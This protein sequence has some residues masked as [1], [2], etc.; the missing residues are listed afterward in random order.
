MAVIR[1]F[2]AVRPR[3]EDVAAVAAVP[4][5]V[6]S[7][8][9]AA[10]L[11]A[12]NPLSFLHVSRSEIDLEPGI[13]P[14]SDAVY[15]KAQENYVKLQQTGVLIREQ[16]DS[17]Y[18]Y[19]LRSGQHSQV[20]LAATFAVDEYDGG[21]ILKHEKT[22][23][24]KE[25]DRTRHILTLRAQTGPVLLTFRPLP[26][27]RAL[28]EEAV[29]GQP[30]YDLTASD[31][32]QHTVWRVSQPGLWVQAFGAV[33]SLYI[34]DG[35]HRAAGASRARARLREESSSWSGQEAANFFLAVA[36]P[37]DQLRILP[38][39]RVVKDLNGMTAQQLREKLHPFVGARAVPE[40]P[41]HCSMYLE[42]QWL[43]VDMTAW[44]TAAASPVGRL[45][46][47]LLQEHVLA[48][49]LGIQD[50]RTDKRI[51]FVGGTAGV[52]ELVRRVDSGQ[53]AVAFSMAPTSLDQLLEISDAGE[54]MPP[55]STWFDPKLRDAIVIHAI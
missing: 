27:I 32:I 20:G 31:G 48:R 42:G 40:G 4:Y 36:F 49:Y 33:P 21:K 51:D 47:A 12:G 11:A 53:A 46:V 1:P 26:T 15:A 37:T 9:E 38:Y 54:I 2:S 7:R 34:A 6:V 19:R 52:E 17:L 45:D 39:D 14:Y 8:E 55:K 5:D 30:L 3:P 50:P 23:K 43:D 35:H 13:D 10:Q 44:A 41:G 25:D 18:V 16:E 22:R 24:D 29:Q 28:F